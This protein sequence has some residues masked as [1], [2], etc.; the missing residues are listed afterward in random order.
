MRIAQQ[1][2]ASKNIAFSPQTQSNNPTVSHSIPSFDTIIVGSGINSLVAAAFLSRSGRSVLV[3]EREQT[4]GGC[5]RSE[6]LTLPG[7]VHD[8]LSMAHPA[9]VAGPVYAHLGTELK[10]AG[11]EYCSNDSPTGVLTSNGEHLVLSTSRE[12]NQQRFEQLHAGDGLAHLQAMQDIE[13]DAETIFGLLGNALWSTATAKTLAK[14]AWAS[15]IHASSSWLGTN[16]TSCRH[17]LESGFHGHAARALL[18]PW[19][20]H[21]GLGPDS[22]MSA[23]MTKVIIHTLESVGMPIP[24]GGNARTVEAFAH[25]IGQHGGQFETGAHVERILVSKGKAQGVRLADGR[26]MHAREVVCNVT[27]TQLYGSLLAEADIPSEVAAQARLYRY[28]KG[29]MQIHLALSEPPQW[30]APELSRVCYLH[31]ADGPNA[32]SCAV[33]EAER[34]LLPAVPTI[35]VAQPCS[36]DTERAPAG[37]SILWIQLPE[38]PRT[39]LGDAAQEITVTKE[40]WTTEVKEAYA[41]RVI[42]MIARH[43]P[44]LMQSIIGRRVL[45]PA[46]LASLNINLVGGDPY[47]GACDMDQY[48]LW[49]PLKGSKNHKTHI[50]NLWHIGA[51][52]HP[53][54]GL[55]GVSG[56]LLAKRLGAV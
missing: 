31:L 25:I 22:P 14:K 18:A 27:P 40:G 38:C 11:L 8:T 21:N 28:G 44:N 17:W 12:Q 43:V 24:K 37:R 48:M 51:S 32:V 33:N 54:P 53:G 19:T 10:K 2:D 3:L 13:R 7:F 1:R 46:D 39:P 41:D 42:R 34:G 35:C 52:T 26:L 30:P 29:N 20:L 23:L 55:G 50:K 16:M 47:G 4:L 56:F 15:G 6:P 5:I 9:F 36:V 49:R 45:S